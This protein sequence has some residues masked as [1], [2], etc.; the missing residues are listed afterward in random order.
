MRKVGRSGWAGGDLQ[1]AEEEMSCR[2]AAAPDSRE[3]EASAA[4]LPCLQ[5]AGSAAGGG[6]ECRDGP[7][8]AGEWSA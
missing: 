2:T 6:G 3:A 5:S 1:A 4:E 8:E 7:G